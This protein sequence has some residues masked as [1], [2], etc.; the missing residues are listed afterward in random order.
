M[1]ARHCE[2]EGGGGGGPPL[3]DLQIPCQTSTRHS[4]APQHARGRVCVLVPKLSFSRL[5]REIVRDA[6]AA[7]SFP[8]DIPPS[9]FLSG[10]P[11]GGFGPLPFFRESAGKS[12]PSGVE[13]MLGGARW[14]RS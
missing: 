13:K 14:G 5:V 1:H 4:S 7:F 9:H 2:E 10:N 12:T 8:I 6:G 3:E 11:H